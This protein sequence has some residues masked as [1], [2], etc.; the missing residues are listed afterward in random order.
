VTGV[1]FMFVFVVKCSKT[2]IITI[3]VV[4]FNINKIIIIVVVVTVVM[5]VDDYCLIMCLIPADIECWLWYV[6]DCEQQHST[7]INN[8]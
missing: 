7:K 3:M 4:F 2:L 6:A 5:S 8:C 1:S